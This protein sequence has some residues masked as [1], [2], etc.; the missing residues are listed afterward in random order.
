LGL[1]SDGRI[2]T[3]ASNKDPAATDQSCVV[4]S[5][6]DADGK[7]LETI[8]HRA[9]M[10]NA[11]AHERVAAAPNGEW[12]AFT[13]MDRSVIWWARPGTQTT[14]IEGSPK[15]EPLRDLSIDRDGRCWVIEGGSKLGVRPAGT[16]ENARPIYLGW[17]WDGR[18]DL[19]CVRA[20]HSH[21]LVGCAN[22]YLRIVRASDGTSIKDCACFDE[23][24]ATLFTESANTV[25][26]VDVVSDETLAVAGTEDGRLWLF[27]LPTGE[28][29]GGWTA[30]SDRVTT[31]AFDRTGEWLASGGR[32]R[33]VRIWQRT[34]DG[35][36]QYMTLAAPGAGRVRQLVFAG[37][38]RLLVLHEN[39]SAVRVWHLDRL[40][41]AF[42]SA[43]IGR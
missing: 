10:A 17:P 28:K 32:D 39:E 29:L 33:L 12:T 18:K 31:V 22:G 11:G 21:V 27:R 26:A 34:G 30:H 15:V 3:I 16:G 19:A 25:H 2:G 7:L 36:H 37:D 4:A 8:L 20:G 35:F 23:S 6:W 9:N 38:D 1:T 41:E 14:L 43:G 5:I 40:A 13:V 24:P 42:R